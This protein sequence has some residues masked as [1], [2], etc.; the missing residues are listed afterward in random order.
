[1]KGNILRF[2]G[3]D[4]IFL[5]LY[6]MYVAFP[7]WTTDCKY[8]IDTTDTLLQENLK[9]LGYQGYLNW[10]CTPV[11]PGIFEAALTPQKLLV[12][13]VLAGTSLVSLG[14]NLFRRA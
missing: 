8:L 5:G 13:L 3:I 9:A 12:L 1:M 6:I 4:L 2:V 7:L 11:Q 14:V 10:Y